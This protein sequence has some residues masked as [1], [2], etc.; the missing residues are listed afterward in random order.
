WISSS[1]GIN[2]YHPET[3]DFTRYN[4]ADGFANDYV[5]G[6]V[7]DDNGHLWLSTFDGLIQ[8]DPDELTVKNYTA[9]DGLASERFGNL[10]YGKSKRTGRLFF[11]GLEGL[12]VFHPDSIVVDS[13]FKPLVISD[14]KVYG[15]KDGVTKPTNIAGIDYK[16]EVVLSH[17]ENNFT[18]D[19][20]YL[21][22]D[23][24]PS[25]TYAYQLGNNPAD[26][27]NLMDNR[28]LTLNNLSPGEYPLRIR[29]TNNAGI[30]DP[31][32]KLLNIIITPPWWRTNLAF[33]CYFVLFLGASYGLYYFLLNRQLAETRYQQLQELDTFKTQFYTNITH[34]FRTPLTIISG[35]AEKLKQEPQKWQ[36]KGVEM[37]RRNSYNLLR[38]VNQLLDLQ[39]LESGK[40]G[41]NLQQG[42]VIAYLKYL[43]ESFQSYAE[44]R[45]VKTHF[46]TNVAE[47]WMDFDSDKL[48]A[49][50]NNLL[51]NAI[52]F[53][54]SGG[55]VYCQID[56]L[57]NPKSTDQLVIKI[58]D[59]GIGIPSEKLPYIFNR[60]YQVDGSHTREG[61]GTGVGLAFTK[62]LVQFLD[63][64]IQVKSQVNQGTT[65]QLSF[66]IQQQATKVS[67][68]RPLA[69]TNWSWE[70]EPTVDQV[71]NAIAA[72]NTLK[73]QPT[74]LVIEDNLDVQY[75]LT[76]C[77]QNDYQISY[78]QNGATGIEKAIAEI[79]DIIISDVMMP[80]KD[81]FEVC[82]TLK[83]EP[84]TSHIPLILL[85]AKA[86][87]ADKIA[88]LE[89]GADAYLSKPFHPN[90]LLARLR[91]LIELRQVL[92]AT[93]SQG[94]SIVKPVPKTEDVFV[95]KV[96][97]VILANLATANFGPNELA[98]EMA[99]SRSQLHRKLKALTTFS[100]SNYMN[101]V[102][103]QAA[104]EL[105]LQTDKSVSEI[106]YEVGFSSPQYF[107][108]NFSNVFGVTATEF[109][110]RR[111][112]NT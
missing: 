97:Q 94:V 100:T 14:F 85:T 50:I 34:E 60:F 81:G 108:T 36:E 90:E 58:K 55:D 35:M 102:R 63:G 101:R 71:S 49:I 77:L 43:L 48:A 92:Q 107:S 33:L 75:Y 82:Q 7:V 73:N 13:L 6:M 18:L 22:Y 44:S 8:F 110:E 19:F 80:E 41:I 31:T 23:R 38:L 17:E 59:T 12:T 57:T 21:E 67:S 74:V 54:K 70:T 26:W 68:D 62:E 106:A 52:K 3:D 112:S 51:S 30:V 95:Q 9:M 99:V 87:I 47:V 10:A 79:P 76:S 86:T 89:F 45:G 103:L 20:S 42:E 65:F 2:L 53:S 61:E 88:G 4:R 93:Y 72:N 5:V 27:I 98:K 32:Q 56:R 111:Q 29:A 24:S 11:G 109:R 40:L 16:D 83:K 105:L 1:E 91:N 15:T 104:K 46:L 84:I 37:I 69:N 39:K 66:P 28:S 25:V 96:Q 64:T 78:A